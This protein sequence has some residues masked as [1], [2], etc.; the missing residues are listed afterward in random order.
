MEFHF[1]KN[2]P[3]IKEGFLEKANIGMFERW[4]RRYFRLQKRCLFYFKKET[5]DEPCG[6]IPLI[7]IELED[8]PSKKGRKYGFKVKILGNPSF[9][10]R[11]EYLIQADDNQT[12]Q[13]W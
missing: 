5:D 8:L 9:A 11:D 2:L 13:T 6:N 12:R 1:D 4:Q 3:T 7:N 10:K